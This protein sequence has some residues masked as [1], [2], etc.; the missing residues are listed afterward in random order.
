[1][2]STPKS[3]LKIKRFL[4]CVPTSSLRTIFFAGSTITGLA[5]LGV[6]KE[7]LFPQLVVSEPVNFIL[8]QDEAPSP[9]KSHCT[10]VAERRS[11]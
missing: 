5:Y 9:L 10:R 6:L 7:W 3:F 1:M 8:Q 4:C 2:H 11:P